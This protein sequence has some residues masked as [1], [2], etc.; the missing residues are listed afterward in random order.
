MIAQDA[1]SLRAGERL[2]LELELTPEHKYAACVVGVKPPGPMVG[3]CNTAVNEGMPVEPFA[4][5]AAVRR[6][7]SKWA[8]LHMAPASKELVGKLLLDDLDCPQG[9]VGMTVDPE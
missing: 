6:E 7:D 9:W 1:F 8:W 4:V 5:L 3:T 2:R